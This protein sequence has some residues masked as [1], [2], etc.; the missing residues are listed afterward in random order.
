M[1]KYFDQARQADGYSTPTAVRNTTAVQE[2]LEETTKSL[3]PAREVS[4]GF[5]GRCKSVQLPV[6][7]DRPVIFPRNDFAAVAL[8]SY[9]A[10]RT[11]LLRLQTVQRFRSV[12]LTSAAAAEGKTLTTMNL[13]LCLAQ[14]PDFRVLV[15][16]SDLRTCGLTRLFAQ[17][18]GPGLGNILEGNAKYEDAILRTQNPN[19]FLL[20][21]GTPSSPA[22][23]LFSGK[24]WK[25]LIAW[26]ST[27]FQMILVDSPPVLAVA[28]F[29]QII[30]ACDGTLVVV[31]ALQTQREMLRKAALRIDA[32]KLLGVVFN[33]ARTTEQTEY[34][35]GY[36]SA[37]KG[38]DGKANGAT[39]DLEPAKIS[40]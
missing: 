7:S 35:Y 23:E 26:C 20:G 19:L 2:V 36:G 40:R 28:D 12:V 13:A 34:Q 29:E 9:R 21:A 6:A 30:S 32:K 24:R 18:D 39:Q 37:S 10:L 15:V 14:V 27:Q 22:P 5:M 8:E 1:S 11:R 17:P 25:D 3:V 31:R 33:G 4:E 38:S 16:D